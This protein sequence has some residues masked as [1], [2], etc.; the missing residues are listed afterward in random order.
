VSVGLPAVTL[1]YTKPSAGVQ[2]F[3]S[4]APSLDPSIFNEDATM[5]TF[6]DLSGCDDLVDSTQNFFATSFVA[7]DSTSNPYGLG[8]TFDAKLFDMQADSGATPC[9]SDETCL[10]AEAV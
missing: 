8:D 3:D 9:V 5:D 10:A 6:F 7:H 1:D 2:A 4:L